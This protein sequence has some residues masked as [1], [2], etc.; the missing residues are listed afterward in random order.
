MDSKNKFQYQAYAYALLLTAANF[1][2]SILL[3][4][5]VLRYLV[6]EWKII[7]FDYLLI[8]VVLLNLLVVLIQWYY[9][10]K[11]K[12]LG[13]FEIPKNSF[14]TGGLYLGIILLTILYQFYH[15]NT[16]SINKKDLFYQIPLLLSTIV[17]VPIIEELVYREILIKILG[18]KSKLTFIDLIYLSFL[19]TL[20]HI[21]INSIN[22]L[23]LAHIFIMGI[24][25]LL[26]RI[27]LGLA[28]SIVMHI[29]INGIAWLVF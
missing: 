3:T 28:A 21:D 20:I 12:T 23:Y 2:L 7:S 24:F 1:L 26:I 19:F 17:I 16:P 8:T 5:F 11:N 6:S 25:L 22:W 10:A 14:I 18:I 13:I 27:R 4:F 9:L 29:V 15:G